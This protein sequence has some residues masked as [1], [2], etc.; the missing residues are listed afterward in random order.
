MGTSNLDVVLL[1]D[2]LE[3]IF[4]GSELGKF[5]MHRSSESSSEVSRAGGNVSEMGVLGELAVL[6]NLGGGSGESAEDS[7]DIGTGLH[8]NNSELILFVDP[9]QESLGI[10]VEDTT[11]R[12]PITVEI[13]CFEESVT[14]LEKEMVSDELV[15]SCFIHSFERIESTLE[16]IIEVLSGFN[17]DVHDL[18]S[19][20]LRDTWAKRVSCEV[21]SN[22]DTGGVDHGLL[23]FSERGVCETFGVH[24]SLVGIIDTMTVIIFNDSVK[25]FVEFGVGRVRT[26]VEANTRIEVL[27][28]REAAGLE[29]DSSFILLVFVLLPNLFGKFPREGR[30]GLASREESVII[31]KLISALEGGDRFMMISRFGR[32]SSNVV[33]GFTGVSHLK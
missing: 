12:R 13:A 7:L 29:R 9:D 30:F 1:G 2:L 17:N 14:F 21:S 11:T 26:S 10:I 18:E 4:L 6:L 22:T 20:I 15:L 28:T 23:S 32:W 24:I 8:R 16:I 19:L 5:D 25:E 27:D 31:D 33:G 3:L